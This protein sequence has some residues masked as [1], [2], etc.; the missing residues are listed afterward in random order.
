MKPVDVT[1]ST[2]IDFGVENDKKDPKFEVVD[3]VRIWKYKS[4]LAKGYVLNWSKDVFVIKQVAPWTYVI[5]EGFAG[6]FYK[7]NSKKT[8]Q[9]EFRI[10]KAIKRKFG[11]LH[12]KWKGNDN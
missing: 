1:L 5:S 10:K 7:K 9:T 6:T 3:H 12:V 8:N 11:K 2:Y 4:I